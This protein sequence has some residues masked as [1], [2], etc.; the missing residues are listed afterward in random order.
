MATSVFPELAGVESIQPVQQM[1]RVA[2]IA[3]TQQQTAQQ[4]QLFPSV[5]AQQQVAAQQA[6]YQWNATQAINRAFQNSYSADGTLDENALM[7]N[8][9]QAGYGAMA[10]A[11]MEQ[12]AKFQ[13]SVANLKE[14]TAKIKQQEID[15]AGQLAYAAS[16]LPPE[17]QTGVLLHGLQNVQQLYPQETTPIINQ[18]QQDPSQGPAIIQNLIASSPAAQKQRNE[19]IKA[20]AEALKP[21]TSFFDTATNQWVGGGLM[22]LDAATAQAA[23]I[24]AG[25]M[26][27]ATMVK[28]IGEAVKAGQRVVQANGHMLLQDLQGN[29]IKDMGFAPIITGLQ[30]QYGSFGGASSA[31]GAAQAAGVPAQITPE[32]AAAQLRQVQPQQQAQPP[33]QRFAVPSQEQPTPQTG[34]TTG[35]PTMGQY[36]PSSQP[37]PQGKSIFQPKVDVFAGV[38]FKYREK[39]VDDYQK[40]GAAWNDALAGNDAMQ[41]TLNLARGGNLVSYRYAPDTGVLTLQSMEGGSKRP[42]TIALND[43]KSAGS[44]FDSVTQWFTGHATGE[45]IDPKIIDDMSAMH[46]A[47]LQVQNT[48]YNNALQLINSTADAV[49][50]PGFPNNHFDPVPFKTGVTVS[51]P[52]KPAPKVNQSQTYMYN[53]RPYTYKFDGKNWVLQP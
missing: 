36:V 13:Q 50:Q 10:P 34:T 41:S 2:D 5:L 25:Q 6:Q 18:L 38:P 19:D 27:P 11:M 33:A 23:G 15:T 22:P 44:I 1:Q 39:L 32:Q 29:T 9:G 51:A 45:S 30:M 8:V 28:D 49:R 46:N 31:A 3:Q 42:A 53:G 7:R 52:A 17:A 21:G 24:P 48:K 20:R 47:M 37:I 26:L 35:A 40:A 43:Y 4:R 16:K 12:Y 14:T